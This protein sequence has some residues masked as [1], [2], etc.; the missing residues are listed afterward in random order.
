MGWYNIVLFGF[1]FARFECIWVGFPG[2]L[3]VGV[4][5]VLGWY[6]GFSGFCVIVGHAWLLLRFA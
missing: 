2:D 3:V 6:L 4:M 5:V 1:G